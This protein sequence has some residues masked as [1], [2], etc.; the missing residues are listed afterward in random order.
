MRTFHDEEIDRI[1]LQIDTGE[2]LCPTNDHLYL[3]LVGVEIPP[4][5]IRQYKLYTQLGR[6]R[7]MINNSFEN[8]KFSD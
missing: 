4:E 8:P 7:K 1:L 5:V 6:I 3:L 2:L